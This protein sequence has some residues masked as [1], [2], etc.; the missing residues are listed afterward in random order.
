MLIEKR[1]KIFLENNSDN[2]YNKDQN[3]ARDNTT[4]WYTSN[5]ESMHDCK[6]INIE[7]CSSNIVR[8]LPGDCVIKQE[9]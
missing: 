5:E 7:V 9:F 6:V 8:N 1:W 2:Y 3:R 4:K